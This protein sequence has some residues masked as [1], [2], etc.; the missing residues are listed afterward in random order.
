MQ[1]GPLRREHRKKTK[2]PLALALGGK[3][4]R[5]LRVGEDFNSIE[6]HLPPS[7]GEPFPGLRETKHERAFHALEVRL[8]DAKFRACLLNPTWVPVVAGNGDPRLR[9]SNRCMGRMV[10]LHGAEPLQVW[11]RL[12]P[13]AGNRAVCSFDGRQGAGKFRT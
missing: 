12:C 9:A 7:V 11:D 5:I 8:F 3:F 4:Q 10:L 6:L 1:Q 13:G 2:F